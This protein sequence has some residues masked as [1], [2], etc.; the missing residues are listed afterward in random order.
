MFLLPSLASP[1][2]TPFIRHVAIPSD[3]IPVGNRSM[4]CHVLGTIHLISDHDIMMQPIAVTIGLRRRRR[5]EG[6]HESS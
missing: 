1:S 5:I 6:Y 3:S 4:P 2:T